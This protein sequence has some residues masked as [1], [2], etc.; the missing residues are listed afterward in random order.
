MLKL[1]KFGGAILLY[2]VIFLGILAINARFNQIESNIN[3]N[4]S[5]NK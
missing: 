1:K 2:C 3:T 4:L 5:I